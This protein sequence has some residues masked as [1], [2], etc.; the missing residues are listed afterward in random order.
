[1]EYWSFGIMD[2]EWMGFFNTPVLHHSSAPCTRLLRAYGN[3][4]IHIFIG[5]RF[6]SI[7]AVAGKSGYPLRFEDLIWK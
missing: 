1:L 5:F 7:Y 3:L 4:R 2:G 6:A